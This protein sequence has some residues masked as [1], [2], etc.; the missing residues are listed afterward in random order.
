MGKKILIKG[1]EAIGEAAIRANCMYYFGYRSH[2]RA[3]CWSI[4][5]HSCRSAVVF[6]C[7]AKVSLPAPAWFMVL[8]LPDIAP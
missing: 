6:S 8:Q 5:Q 4:W 3:S 2:R 7:K 1:N